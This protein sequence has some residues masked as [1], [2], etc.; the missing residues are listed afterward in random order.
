MHSGEG[1]VENVKRRTVQSS[2]FIGGTHDMR[3]R[4]MDT[5]ALVQ[6]Y[7]KPDIYPIMTCN[8]N[9]DEIKNELYPSQTP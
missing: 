4:Y 7:G 5:M 1:S 9:W 3:H 8:I 2:S 6:K